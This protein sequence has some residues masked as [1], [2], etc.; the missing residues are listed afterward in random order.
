[1]KAGFPEVFGLLVVIGSAY[2]MFGRSAPLGASEN[3][4]G[5][6]LSSV[7]DPNPDYGGRTALRWLVRP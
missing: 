6:E 2:L 5:I 4:I 3:H 1:M 7:G